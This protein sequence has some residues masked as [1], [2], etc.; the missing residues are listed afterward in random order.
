MKIVKKL[1]AILLALALVAALAVPAMAKDATLMNVGQFT[2]TLT[3][4]EPGQRYNVYRLLKYT[5]SGYLY[6]LGNPDGAHGDW[7][8][9]NG[10]TVPKVN[11][12]FE[13]ITTKDKEGSSIRPFAG[14]VEN[15]AISYPELAKR[16]DSIA[17]PSAQASANSATISAAFLPDD[18]ARQIYDIVRDKSTG[19]EAITANGGNYFFHQVESNESGVAGED[20]KFTFTASQNMY[21]LITK[22]DYNASNSNDEFSCIFRLIAGDGH[23]I[24]D[25]APEIKNPEIEVPLPEPKSEKPEIHKTIGENPDEIINNTGADVGSQVTFTLKGTAPG[26]NKADSYLYRME[27]TLSAGLA[28]DADSAKVQVKNGE[29]AP[30]VLTQN[31]DYTIVQDGQK[32]TFTFGGDKGLKDIEAIKDMEN[33]QIIVTYRATLGPTAFIT[34]VETNT[35]ELVYNHDGSEQRTPGE[36]VYVY[37]F[38]VQVNKR[39]E[40]E[41]GEALAGAEF[42]LVKSTGEAAYA[43]Y[44]KTDAGISWVPV[45]VEEGKSLKD[46]LSSIK[47]QITTVTTD[48]NGMA[49]FNGL[50]KG[51]YQLVELTAPNGYNLLEQ[52]QEIEVSYTFVQPTEGETLNVTHPVA[53]VNKKGPN[54]PSTGGM[55]TT[56]FYIGGGILVAGA[57][58]VLFRRR[59]S[60]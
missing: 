59:R 46:A 58:V 17:I 3:G 36:T 1:L 26:L 4:C 35:V 42:A 22:G 56:L 55:G 44:K 9:Y 5:T 57:A 13:G 39:A 15:G 60:V 7:S 54:L 38:T 18:V 28:F 14:V 34:D 8:E 50:N 51:N 21:Y 2:I 30:V 23:T 20:G 16:F 25:D 24:P 52:P 37:D 43:A 32:I 19:D 48:N 49:V 6:P 45:T 33:P 12:A 40:T 11:Q 47:D 31:T 10:N 53:V 29:S 27:D 41:E